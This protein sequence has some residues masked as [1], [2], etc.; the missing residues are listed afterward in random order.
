MYKTVVCRPKKPYPPLKNPTTKAT[1]DFP[2]VFGLGF[3]RPNQL[4]LQ[5]LNT[6]CG[7]EVAGRALEL[8]RRRLFEFGGPTWRRMGSQ[9]SVIRG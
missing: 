1:H 8:R 6:S 9:D 4:G 7:L 5:I 3:W 2:Y